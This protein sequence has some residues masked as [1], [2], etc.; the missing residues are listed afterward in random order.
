[1]FLNSQRTIQRVTCGSVYHS[2]DNLVGT[3]YKIQI[4]A[5]LP[6]IATDIKFELQRKAEMK[7]EFQKGILIKIV[8]EYFQ[9][10][11]AFAFCSK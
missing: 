3:K 2:C 1:M 5:D 11:V 8:L 10:Y 4:S 7:F 9:S 6:L